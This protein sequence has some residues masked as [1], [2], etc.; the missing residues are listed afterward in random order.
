MNIALPPKIIRDYLES[1]FNESLITDSKEFRVNSIF[2][3]DY[4]KK[5]Y[6]NLNTGFWI[7]FKAGETGNFYQ[8]VAHIENISYKQAALLIRKTIFNSTG[9]LF[10]LDTKQVEQPIVVVDS[11]K[12][13]MKNW[14]LVLP[15]RDLTSPLLVKRLAAK[16]AI[17]RGFNKHPFFVGVKGRTFSRLIIPYYDNEEFFY[18]QARA[19]NDQEPR[20]L[21]PKVSENGI[22]S[23][24]ILYPYNKEKNYVI[25]TE[26]V[27]DAMSLQAVGFNATCTHGCHLSIAQAK[28]IKGKNVV[29]A[30]DNDEAGRMGA[31][32]SRSQLL[33]MR[34]NKIGILKCPPSFKDWNDFFC[35]DKN[36]LKAWVKSNIK[37]YTW[38]ANIIEQLS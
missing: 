22:K 30:Y 10:E 27:M 13:E 12:E 6:I 31:K 37:A 23:S 8:L 15:D 7:D 9:I 17:S 14:K 20:Y 2:V 33:L 21:N 26:G 25:L 4:K 18:Y 3:S 38:D 34:S 5:L 11:I 16:Y 24:N 36:V 32:Q 28:E 1:K 35:T 29:I 19:L